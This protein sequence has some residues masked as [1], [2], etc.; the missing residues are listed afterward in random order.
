MVEVNGRGI[1][2]VNAFTG[3][4]FLNVLVFFKYW[5]FIARKQFASQ[6]LILCAHETGKIITFPPRCAMSK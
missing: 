1:E 5:A 6:A 3:F 2:D 4:L